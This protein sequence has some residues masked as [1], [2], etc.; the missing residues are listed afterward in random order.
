MFARR[1]SLLF[2]ACVTACSGSVGDNGIGDRA[3]D[4]G[5]GDAAAAAEPDAGPVYDG[6]SGAAQGGAGGQGG[7][8]GSPSSEL[9][10]VPPAECQSDPSE[11]TPCGGDITGEWRMAVIC[12]DAD[13][14]TLRENLM[15]PELTQDFTYDYRMRV[16]YQSS[17]SYT[18]W[19]Y[20]AAMQTVLLPDSCI[21]AEANG[22]CRAVIG[23]DDTD[24]SDG[25]TVTIT[26]HDDGCRIEAHE[27]RSFSEAGTWE[28]SGNELTMTSAVGPRT[29]EYCV[30][31]TSLVVRNVN[32]ATN[33]VSW[34]VF[35]RL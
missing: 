15:C 31:G 29:S 35:E 34:G 27:Q 25:R 10:D 28:V 32:I 5:G 19:V 26:M 12:L 21:P 24:D 20:A 17:G 3:P 30:N 2:W 13:I 9:D 11:F 1:C 16:D 33:E 18:A 4:A 8:G 7:S 23:E 6:D 14:E 22:D